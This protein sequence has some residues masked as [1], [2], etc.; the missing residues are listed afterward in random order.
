MDIVLFGEFNKVQLNTQSI[1]RKTNPIFHAYAIISD[2]SGKTNGFLVYKHINIT[3]LFLA[4]SV[5][6]LSFLL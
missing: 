6:P 5:R 1:S 4:Q 3:K 2:D